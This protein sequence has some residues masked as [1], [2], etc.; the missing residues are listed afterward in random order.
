MKLSEVIARLEENPKLKFVPD[1]EPNKYIHIGDDGV[2]R[3][4]SGTPFQVNLKIVAWNAG[5]L[6]EYEW[7]QQ[8]EAV[9]FVTAINSG[10]KIR[11]EG[12]NAAYLTVE[13]VLE[14]LA[15]RMG[16]LY[17]NREKYTT[18]LWEIEP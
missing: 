11:P 15:N 18:G 1:Q 13:K 4:G 6:D 12:F 16:Q 5:T 17:R 2:L 10:K 3:W 14:L 9:D 8:H 7:R